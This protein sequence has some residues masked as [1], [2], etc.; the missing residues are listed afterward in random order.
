[1]C[2]SVYHKT[3]VN[4]KFWNYKAVWFKDTLNFTLSFLQNRF[5]SLKNAPI[6]HVRHFCGDATSL[7]VQ[8]NSLNKNFLIDSADGSQRLSLQYQRARLRRPV[9]VVRPLCHTGLFR[10]GDD[11]ITAASASSPSHTSRALGGLKVRMR[12]GGDLWTL[13]ICSREVFFLSFSPTTISDWSAFKLAI[14]IIHLSLCVHEK[15]EHQTRNLTTGRFGRNAADFKLSRRF[16]YANILWWWSEA[17]MRSLRGFALPGSLS[18]PRLKTEGW[19]NREIKTTA[20]VAEHP[21]R[22]VGC[23]EHDWIDWV[24]PLKSIFSSCHRES[25]YCRIFDY[26]VVTWWAP[27]K[28]SSSC[29]TFKL[30]ECPENGTAWSHDI[31]WNEHSVLKCKQQSPCKIFFPPH[32]LQETQQESSSIQAKRKDVEV[33]VCTTQETFTFQCSDLGAF[34]S[35]WWVFYGEESWTAGYTLSTSRHAA[36][37]WSML[38]QPQ[39]K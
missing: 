5:E 3:N 29:W 20:D 7:F 25:G 19:R 38:K 11:V 27:G 32:K 39:V 2:S 4:R 6:S 12:V 36:T 1:M 33:A 10:R 15:E 23:I 35:S 17:L 9:W 31:L 14:H 37:Y 30:S 13:S 34:I 28:D 26:V 22:R 21:C 16:C 18:S 8:L 24:F